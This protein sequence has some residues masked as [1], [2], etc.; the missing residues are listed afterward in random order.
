MRISMF[1]N[2]ASAIFMKSFTAAPEGELMTPMRRGRN[3]TGFLCAESNSPSAASFS[4]RM[5]NCRCR[6]PTPHS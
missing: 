2:R 1:G 5:A 3:G 4:Y 6:S